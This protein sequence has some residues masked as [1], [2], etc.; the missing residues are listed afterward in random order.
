MTL[1]DRLF[2]LVRSEGPYHLYLPNDQ[3]DGTVLYAHAS[4][5]SAEGLVS[6]CPA[7]LLLQLASEK[8]KL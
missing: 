2:E 4:T 5:W 7:C 6:T 1:Y 8:D 3:P